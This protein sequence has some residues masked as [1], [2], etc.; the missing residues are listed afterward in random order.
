MSSGPIFSGNEQ[1]NPA[2]LSPT[3]ASLFPPGVAAAELRTPG[4]LEL[5][6]S[7]ERAAVAGAVETRAREFAAGRLCARRALAELGL[8]RPVRAAPDRQ[9]IWPEGV[10]GSITHTQGY[11][12]AVVAPRPVLAAL[13]LDTE[14]AGRVKPE[15]WPK[16]CVDEEIA[17]LESLDREEQAV[18]ATLIFAAKEA[19]YKCQYPS[20]RQWLNFG[21][22]RVAVGEGGEVGSLCVVPLRPIAF[23]ARDGLAAHAAAL[24]G[25]FRRHQDLISA[26][27]FVEAPPSASVDRS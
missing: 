9:P 21:D 2:L 12:A 23:L 10:V 25:R 19:F 24:C 3:I 8:E 13:G 14:R 11:A 16:I 22:V 26:G 6:D 15:L 17:W 5:L 27:L 7:S 4:D 18:G 1:R 20:T